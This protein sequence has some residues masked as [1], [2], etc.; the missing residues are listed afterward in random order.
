MSSITRPLMTASL[1][2]G[3]ANVN[4]RLARQTDFRSFAVMLRDAPTFGGVKVIVSTVAGNHLA[5][6]FV[7]NIRRERVFFSMSIKKDFVRWVIVE[8]MRRKKACGR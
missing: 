1:L 4:D 7:T 6:F 3:S 8:H 2:A 5:I